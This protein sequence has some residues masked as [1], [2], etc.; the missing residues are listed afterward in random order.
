M[1][2]RDVADYSLD[3]M[4]LDLEAVVDRQ[5]LERFVLFAPLWAGLVAIAYAA[6][7]PQRVSHLILFNSLARASDVLGTPQAQGLAALF[8]KDWELFTETLAHYA[9]GWSAGESARRYAALIRESVTQEAARAWLG[10][11]TQF[12]VREFLPQVKAPTLVVHNRQV[13]LPELSVARGLASGIP[14]ASLVVEERA[15][16]DVEAAYDEF[17][18]EGEEEAAA[19]PPEPGAFRTVLFTDVEGSTALTQ[20]LGD[21]RARELLREHE[22]MVR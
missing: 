19:E 21:A 7:H 8:D 11:A 5:G 13:A 15:L 16:Y 22:R 10:A 12:D 18:G 1:S 14:N 2:D 3:A 9:F 4:T 6:R 17:L 20:R